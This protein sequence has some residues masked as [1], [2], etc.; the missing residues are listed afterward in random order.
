MPTKIVISFDVILSLFLYCLDMSLVYFL[1]NTDP[2]VM[3]G[4]LARVADNL[5]QTRCVVI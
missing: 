3:D 2:D 1:D 5:G 4:V